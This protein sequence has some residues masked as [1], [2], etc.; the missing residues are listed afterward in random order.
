MIARHWRGWTHP[1]DADDYEALL[2]DKVTP[3]LREIAGYQGGYV[4]RRETGGQ[5]E[6]VVVNLFSSLDAVKAFA[7]P[8][9]ETAVFDPE[10]KNL[11]ARAE[12]KAVHYEVRLAPGK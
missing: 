11:L 5:T 3:R 1:E 9:Y 10:A 6:F 4:L 2:R 7:G 8:D 12:P